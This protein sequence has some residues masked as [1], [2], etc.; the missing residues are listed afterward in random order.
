VGY[1]FIYL[2]PLGWGFPLIF[3]LS[4]FFFLVIGVETKFIT[5]ECLIKNTLKRKAAAIILAG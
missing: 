2:L 3:F 5:I 1:L 4:F